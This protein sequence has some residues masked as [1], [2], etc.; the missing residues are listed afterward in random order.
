MKLATAQ[1]RLRGVKGSSFLTHGSDSYDRSGLQVALRN[2]GR[3][4]IEEQLRDQETAAR[5]E[6]ELEFKL[7][8]QQLDLWEEMEESRS[9]RKFQGEAYLGV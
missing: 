8:C 5:E 9:G 3:A 7:Y 1:K 6:E 4:L 2:L